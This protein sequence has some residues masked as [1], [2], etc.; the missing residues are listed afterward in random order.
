MPSFEGAFSQR[1]VF[2]AQLSQPM[3]QESG[4]DEALDTCLAL[5]K[6]GRLEEAGT[7][8]RRYVDD[9]PPSPRAYYQLGFV[10]FRRRNYPRSIE[11]LQESIALGSTNADAH[12]ML[13]LEFVMGAHYEAA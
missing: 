8:L 9:H 2:A 6:S 13:G 5:I 3:E 12:K 7:A 10:Y 11:A 4:S 1:P